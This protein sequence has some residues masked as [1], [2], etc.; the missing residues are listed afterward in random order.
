MSRSPSKHSRGGVDSPSRAP[1]SSLTASLNSTSLGSPCRPSALKGSRPAT[2]SIFASSGSVS[3]TQT[4]RRKTSSSPSKSR[5]RDDD[6]LTGNLTGNLTGTYDV[7]SRRSSPSKSSLAAGGGVGRSGVVNNDWDP[8]AL[9]GE[10]KRSPSKKSGRHYDRYIPSRQTSTNGNGD[11]TGPI[12]LP[13]AQSSTD[14]IPQTLEDAQHTAD[15]S[16]TLGINSD[17]RILSFFAEPPMPQTEHSS[18][19]AQY[20]RLPNKGSAASSTSS[21]NAAS[22]RKIPSQPDRVL[23]APGMLDDYY[24]NLIDW[25]STN[26]VAIGLAESV[27][28]WNAATGDVTELCHVGAGGDSSVLTEG[29]EYVCSV[30]FTEDG[31]HLAVGLASGPVQ[32]YDVC[33]GQLIRTM[34]GHPSRVPSLSW[35]GAIVASGCRSGE[36]WNSDVRVAQHCVA[37]MK[38]HR[39][40]VCGLEWRPEISGGLSGGGQ[41]LLASGGNDNVVNVWDGR[42]TNAP[43]MSKT[44]HT[45][46]VKALAWCPW[47]SSLLASGGGSSDRTIHFW[48]TTQSARLN[49][50]VTPSQVTSIVWNPHGKELLSSHGVPDHHLSLWSY[51]SL[52]KIADIPHA[53]Q[54]RI[55][56]SAL[57]PDGTTVAT[58][59]SDEDLKFWKVFDIAKKG[60]SSGGA[61]RML[62]GKEVDENDGIGRKGKT[63]ISVR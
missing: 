56:H 37:Q 48:N 24:L 14:N 36:I 30:K 52:G 44:N 22:R 11:H 54:A 45:A 29:D 41:G 50:L 23:D 32:I 2:K 25:S 21:T 26:L 39:G 60:G 10:S 53:H 49:S 31:S 33:A 61:G 42:M 8:S 12:L 9:A 35:S 19:L 62:S 6:D 16:R 40:E 57:S 5:R 3:T 55:L 27:Y 43:K 17:Q 1:L 20:A 58:A 34:Q 13:S 47:N 4:T 28:V 38:G 51:P 15:L 59:S 18:L 63:G 46:A 7:P